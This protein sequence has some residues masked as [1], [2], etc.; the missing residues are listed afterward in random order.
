MRSTATTIDRAY[1]LEFRVPSSHAPRTR[2]PYAHN[3]VFHLESGDEPPITG[4]GEAAPYR[5]VFSHHSSA[6][7]AA[8]VDVAVEHLNGARIRRRPRQAI[9]DI[10]TITHQLAALADEASDPAESAPPAGVLAG[11]EAALLDL[12]ARAAKTTTAS[13]LGGRRQPVST[14]RMVDAERLIQA[15]ESTRA[16]RERGPGVK[17]TGVA[18]RETALTVTSEL[19]EVTR[20]GSTV[21]LELTA[22]LQP[23]EIEKLAEELAHQVNAG[24]LGPQL[25]VELPAG[26]EDTDI[27]D[28]QSQL[29]VLAPGPGGHAGV[30][31]MPQ[32]GSI[33]QLHDLAARG[34]RAVCVDPFRLGGMLTVCSHLGRLPGNPRRRRMGLS[35]PPEVSAIGVRAA[36]ELAAALPRLDYFCVPTADAERAQIQP[37]ETDDENGR[38]AAPAGHGIGAAPDYAR[39][40]RHLTR[41]VDASPATTTRPTYE[42]MPLNSFDND[43]LAPFFSARGKLNSASVLLER[44]ALTRGLNTTRTSRAFFFAEHDDLDRPLFFTPNN[45]SWST[46]PPH[47]L[48]AD[49][50]LTRRILLDHGVPAPR[51]AAF[52]PGQV[53]EAVAF[54]ASLD[55]AVVVKPKKASH[56][57]GVSTD[58]RSAHQIRRAIESL[59]AAG[60]GDRQFLVEEHVPG[61]DYRFLV[62]G[63]RVVSVVLKRPAAVVGDGRSTITELV[64]QKN[65][66]RL[67]NPHARGCLLEFGP[68]A[69]AW[70]SRQDLTP[71]SVLE[72]GRTVRVGSA[73]NIA[74]GGE[75]IEVLDETH[76]S[77]LDLAVRSVRTFP[78]LDH[79]GID[80]MGDHRLGPDRH[81]AAILEINSMPATSLNHFPM[82]GTPR[83][84]SSDIVL[85][86]CALEGFHPPATSDRLS[87]RMLIE[88]RVRGVGYRQWFA[89]LAAAR[90]VAGSIRNLSTGPVEAYVS[91]KSL[92]VWV[93]VSGAFLGPRNAMVHRISTTHVD[94]VHTTG[95]FEVH[96]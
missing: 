43:A 84:V 26:T 58:L 89:E 44:A 50:E 9:A 57:D 21:W 90:G 51:G 80:M 82:F 46:L 36:A 33:P 68:D 66:W 35:V 38:L 11:V 30:L 95:R 28:V 78:G 92:D 85:R 56:G 17:V 16:I 75:S 39:V 83:D 37:A 34:A 73:G 40:V 20:T 62:V 15:P 1:A 74:T 18:D 87:V 49:K 88:G 71:Q 41:Q 25:V 81:V 14:Y 23:A 6:Q 69:M 91:G 27:V 52:D 64:L 53:D 72:A 93:V 47:R 96:R 45:T 94:E 5:P 86:S 2:R 55:A 22:V 77:L 63:D 7:P 54:A 10:R 31:V 29:D 13:L 65:R 12:A 19:A 79:A 8:F 60:F 24:E 3:T 48:T 59:D 32:A 76:P 61:N 70:L 4:A 42:G 67:E